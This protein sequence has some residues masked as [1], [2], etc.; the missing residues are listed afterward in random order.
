MSNLSKIGFS[1]LSHRGR[2]E[3][4][5]LKKSVGRVFQGR[6]KAILVQKESHLLP[7]EFH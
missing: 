7:M 6:Y 1:P 4:V 5:I 3:T 2:R